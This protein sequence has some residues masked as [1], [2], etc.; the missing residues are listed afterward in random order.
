MDHIQPYRQTNH[1]NVVFQ[2]VQTHSRL[3]VL[4]CRELNGYVSEQHRNEAMPLTKVPRK[5]MLGNLPPKI[6]TLYDTAEW[7][8]IPHWDQ[9]NHTV[10]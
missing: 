6:R 4:Q 1:Y 3:E 10:L 5:H 8:A 7:C 9:E 2:I